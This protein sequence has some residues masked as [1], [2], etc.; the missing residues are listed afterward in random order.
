MLA[1]RIQL[2]IKSTILCGLGKEFQ[3]SQ[4][5]ERRLY[6]MPTEIVLEVIES[7]LKGVY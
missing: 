7:Y 3:E 4:V 5:W 1:L 6:K 2:C